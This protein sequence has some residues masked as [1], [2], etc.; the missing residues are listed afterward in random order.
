MERSILTQQQLLGRS[1]VLRGE[2]VEQLAQLRY[3][4]QRQQA[5]TVLLVQLDSGDLLYLLPAHNGLLPPF[6]G[7]EQGAWWVEVVGVKNS[8]TLVTRY[9][10]PPQPEPSEPSGLSELSESP[11][12]PL[13]EPGEIP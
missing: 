4:G 12:Q 1:Y 3:G 13:S 6:R 11:A 2:V 5:E 9:L 8:T 7:H 10:L